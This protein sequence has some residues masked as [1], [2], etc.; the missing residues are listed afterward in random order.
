MPP[1]RLFDVNHSSTCNHPV[2]TDEVC[3]CIVRVVMIT[4][5]RLVSVLMTFLLNR[6]VM[7]I[8]FNNDASNF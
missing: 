7:K 4:T 3:S 2:I 8:P 1:I 6:T 5:I